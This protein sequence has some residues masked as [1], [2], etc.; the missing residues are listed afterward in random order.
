MPA[1]LPHLP[2]TLH[3]NQLIK[4][5][6]DLCVPNQPR[7]RRIVRV[8]VSACKPEGRVPRIRRR[9]VARPERRDLRFSRLARRLGRRI[10]VARVR[11]LVADAVGDDVGVQRLLLTLVDKRVDCLEGEFRNLASVE[12]SLEFHCRHAEPEVE[13]GDSRFLHRAGGSC[14]RGGCG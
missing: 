3:C 12:P 9:D 13:P 2:L 6:A 4:T 1:F 14:C 11:Q 10:R 7:L 8:R 5:T